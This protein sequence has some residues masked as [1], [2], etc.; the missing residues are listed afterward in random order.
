LVTSQAEFRGCNSYTVIWVTKQFF[1]MDQCAF[2]L[3]IF[4]NDIVF[5]R[6]KKQHHQ[7]ILRV[8]F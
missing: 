8:L 5:Q 1:N 6:A 4:V 3:C 2:Y 7:I